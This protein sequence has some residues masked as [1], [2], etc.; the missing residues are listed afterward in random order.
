[1][2]KYLLIILCTLLLTTECKL[3]DSGIHGVSI[4]KIREAREIVSQ[5]NSEA[6]IISAAGRRENDEFMSDPEMTEVFEFMAAAYNPIGFTYNAWELVYEDKEWS[7]SSIVTVPLEIDASIDLEDIEMDVC[8]AWDKI[9]EANSV[10]SFYNWS[11]F[12]PYGETHDESPFF[13]FETAVGAISV[14]PST[15]TGH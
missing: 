11:L 9:T 2:K 13:R 14:H 12:K 4:D 7:I 6:H 8:D 5:Q 10:D 1:M 3:F 15:S